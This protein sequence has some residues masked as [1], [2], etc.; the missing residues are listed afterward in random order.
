LIVD[1]IK[2]SDTVEAESKANITFTSGL[3][4]STQRHR[5]IFALRYSSDAPES[6]SAVTFRRLI[7]AGTKA[8]S[9]FLIAATASVVNDKRHGVS[10]PATVS[11]MSELVSVEVFSKLVL[12]TAARSVRAEK[13]FFSARAL[14]ALKQ[15]F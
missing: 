14:C 3:E 11:G 2:P 12:T 15:T 10:I 6:R 5:A 13:G 8:S 7:A 1:V 4:G 9:R